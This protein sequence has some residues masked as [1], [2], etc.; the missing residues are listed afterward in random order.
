MKSSIIKTLKSIPRDLY[1]FIAAASLFSFSNSVVNAIFNNYLNDT[2]DITD[3]QRGMLEIPREMP[4]F[5]VVFVSALLFFLN[6]RRLAAAANL[7]AALG[8]SALAMLASSYPVMLGWLFMYSVGQHLY[9]PLNSSIAMD[10]SRGNNTG[11]RLGQLMG[12]ANLAAIAGSFLVFIGF[13][14]LNF[15]YTVSFFISAG[16][17]VIASLCFFRMKPDIPRAVKT[18]LVIRKEYA[19]FYWLNILFGTRKQIFLTFAPWV[20]VT[21]FDQPVRVVAVLLFIGGVIG[22]AFNPLLGRAIDRLGERKILMAEAVVLIFVCLGYGFSE[23]LFSKDTAFIVASACFVTDQLLMSVGMARATYIKKIALKPEDVPATLAMGVTI[24]HL[25]SI[26]VAMISG[27]L[28]V[29]IGYEFVFLMG[30]CIALTN[31]FSASAIYRGINPPSVQA[32]P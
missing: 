27:I 8:V 24:D 21:V 28:W 29:T 1:L 25:F 20:L 14:E 6:S 19:L 31:L 22:I 30:A 10:Y 2:F 16:G 11:K 12:V 4:G 23:R 7:I 32:A 18:S 3:F 26:A 15:T 9:L 5:L 17:F 13:K